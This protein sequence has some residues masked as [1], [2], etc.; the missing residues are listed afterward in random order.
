M[1]KLQTDREKKQVA[2]FVSDEEGLVVLEMSADSRMREFGVDIQSKI[3]SVNGKKINSEAEVYS[4]LK[5]NLYNA[6]LKIKDSHGMVKD[7]QFRHNKN[8]RLGILVVPRNV[9]K[10]DIVPVDGGN[11]K[12]VLNSLKGSENKVE[13][14]IEKEND[15]KHDKDVKNKDNKM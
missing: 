3:L 15:G 14:K 2:K 10:E 6:V 8:T 1:L 4:I 9:S 7:I 5:E 13:Y 11:F 12:N